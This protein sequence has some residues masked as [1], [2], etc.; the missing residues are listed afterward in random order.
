MPHPASQ[1]HAAQ[2]PHPRFARLGLGVVV[3]LLLGLG[4]AMM[5]GML[6]KD[7][8]GSERENALA[9][10]TYFTAIAEDED[11][12]RALS[13]QLLRSAEG[14]AQMLNDI[15]PAAGAPLGRFDVE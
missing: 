13:Q 10:Q 11:L 8:A 2:K 1:A 3:A 12:L 6:I 15:A 7:F 9:E 4:G 5:T 14:E